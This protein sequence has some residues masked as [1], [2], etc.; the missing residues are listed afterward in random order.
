MPVDRLNGI[1]RVDLQRSPR[2]RRVV[3]RVVVVKPLSAF[4]RRVVA[5]IDA[6]LL[7]RTQGRLHAAY[8]L[9]PVVMLRTTGAKTGVVRDVALGYFTDGDDVILIASN[10]G[11]AKYP[12][13]YYNLRENPECEL[14]AKSG[15]GCFVAH[16]TSGSDRDRLFSLA[17][18]AYGIFSHYQA[19]TEGIRTIPVLRLT[20]K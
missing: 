7:R 18:G 1:P 9:A 11:R 4:H 6:M 19:S 8:G 15:S 20:A 12:S 17:E 14:F 2:S 5:P 10:Y 13:W 3:S 16:V